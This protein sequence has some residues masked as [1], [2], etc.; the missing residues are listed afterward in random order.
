MCKHAYA[1]GGNF[2]ACFTFCFIRIFCSRFC[3][4]VAPVRELWFGRHFFNAFRVN[5]RLVYAHYGDARDLSWGQDYP[6]MR[7]CSVIFGFFAKKEWSD[8]EG[9][10]PFPVSSNL[11]RQYI[12]FGPTIATWKKALAN[13][14]VISIKENVKKNKILFCSLCTPNG[15]WRVIARSPSPSG[16]CQ[17]LA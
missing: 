8:V 10:T 1:V 9:E 16:T 13:C 6:V 17:I 12:P 7:L 11:S 15:A 14:D 2:V 3:R 5:P 4:Y